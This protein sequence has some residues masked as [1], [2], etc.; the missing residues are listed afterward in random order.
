[1]MF[2]HIG[3]VVKDLKASAELY[4]DILAPL[5][6]RIVEEH[7]LAID[8]G[9]VVISNGKPQSPFLV[10]GEGRPTFWRGN[11][12]PAASP[13]HLCFA[14]PSREAVVRFHCSGLR[15]GAR[16]N[17]APGIRRP[18]FYCAFLIDFDGNNLEAG[19][20]MGQ[21]VGGEWE[22]QAARAGCRCASVETKIKEKTRRG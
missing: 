22:R 9:W 5:G 20:Y 19:L 16:D 18:P 13:I 17:G 2:D 15:G 1:M 4:G 11:S 14:A 8:S 7:W 6:F 21:P 3:I 12:I 10:P